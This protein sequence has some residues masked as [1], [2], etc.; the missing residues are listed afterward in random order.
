ML[1]VL[2]ADNAIADRVLFGSDF[3]VVEN[4]KL[5]ERRIAVRLR[6][7]HSV[8]SCSTRSPG[9]TRHACWTEPGTAAM[10]RA[11]RAAKRATDFARMALAPV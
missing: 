8:R 4:A 2:L 7:V 1:N 5:D 11:A 9:R 10:P 3:Y 6:S